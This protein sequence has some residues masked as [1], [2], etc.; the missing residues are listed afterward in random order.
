MS[1]YADEAIVQRGL[2]DPGVHF[3]PKPI[4]PDQLLSAVARA[5][6]RR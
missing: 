1:G 5:L 2:L 4:T 6:G 3:V